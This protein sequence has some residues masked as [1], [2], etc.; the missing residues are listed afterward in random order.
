MLVTISV[1]LFLHMLFLNKHVGVDMPTGS[2]RSYV[3]KIHA[4]QLWKTRDSVGSS[5]LPLAAYCNLLN[6]KKIIKHFISKSTLDYGR[7]DDV[8]AKASTQVNLL[9]VTQSWR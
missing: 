5:Q 7:L 9:R 1:K 6:Q 4:V 8:Y 3:L 2:M